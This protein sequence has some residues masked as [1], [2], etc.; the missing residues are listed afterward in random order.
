V[1]HPF[2]IV[3]ENLWSTVPLLLEKFYTIMKLTHSLGNMLGSLW[4]S[5]IACCQCASLQKLLKSAIFESAKHARAN[6][7]ST[8]AS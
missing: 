5:Q 4:D 8:K 3:L 1:I 2:F 7:L 6:I